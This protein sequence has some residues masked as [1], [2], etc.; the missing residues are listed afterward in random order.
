M[1]QRPASTRSISAAH[2]HGLERFRVLA[3][4]LVVALATVAVPG[5]AGKKFLTKNGMS[6]GGILQAGQHKRQDMVR[7][8]LHA[9]AQ[10]LFHLSSR[11]QLQQSILHAVW[12]AQLP[13]RG[14]RSV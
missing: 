12:R 2:I 7:A 1:T 10:V 14:K 8:K 9:A 3:L 11:L 6:P 4:L 13:P 5:V